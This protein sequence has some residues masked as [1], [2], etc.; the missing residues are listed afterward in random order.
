MKFH[1][2]V[3]CVCSTSTP[4]WSAVDFLVVS[5]YYFFYY[6]LLIVKYQTMNET[7]NI[8][9]CNIFANTSAGSQQAQLPS[10]GRCSLLDG[11]SKC[12]SPS[13]LIQ[14]G[15]FRPSFAPISC[16][17]HGSHPSGQF[18]FNRWSLELFLNIAF[19]WAYWLVLK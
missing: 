8:N 12:F 15:R 7:A 16:F 2:N 9:I 13:V 1:Q 5:H 19:T 6:Y 4:C 3:C 14:N 10:N 17:E 18:Y 11:Y